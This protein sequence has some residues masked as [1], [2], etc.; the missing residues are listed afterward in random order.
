MYVELSAKRATGHRALAG[1][2][3]ASGTERAPRGLP[4]RHSQAG[5]TQ[6]PL[7]IAGGQGI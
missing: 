7:R 5:A 6:H 4:W 1:G 3:A 2:L